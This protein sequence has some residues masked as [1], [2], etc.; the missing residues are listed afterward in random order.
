MTETLLPPVDARPGPCTDTPPTP[1]LQ[2]QRILYVTHR[3]PYPPNDGARVRAFHAIR[4]LARANAVTVAAPLRGDEA[5]QIAALEALGVRVIAAP[6]PRAAGLMRTCLS[7]GLGRSAS[8]GYFDQPSLRRQLRTLAENG[9]FDLAVVHCSAVAPYVCELPI[10]FKVLDYVDVDSAK[11]LDYRPFAT[12]AKRLL[13]TLEGR[14]LGRL[15]RAMARRFDLCLSTTAFEDA[16]LQALAAT[17]RGRP[18]ASAVVRNGVDLEFFHPSPAP[19]DPDRICFLGRMDYFPNEQAMVRFCADV[20]PRLRA[21]RPNLQLTIVG[22]DPGP[23][24]R[25]LAQLPG[26]E[27]TGRVQDVRPYVWRSAATVAPLLIARGT[28]NKILESMAMGVPVVASELA[29]RGVQAVPGEHLLTAATPADTA[30]AVLSLL[31]TPGERAR[32]ATSARALVERD[33]S[34]TTTLAEFDARLATLVSR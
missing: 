29:G 9:N 19:Y 34:W 8:R 33:Y 20:L 30:E 28:Q 11:W 6:I 10:P 12:P 14:S 4:H 32:L 5:D 1:R 25:A 31:R 22:A 3:F 18:I 13:Y 15:E 2:G 17:T 26:V 23:G 16:T 7:A 27:V 21:E 24:V